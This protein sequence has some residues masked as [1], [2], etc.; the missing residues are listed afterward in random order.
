MFTGML[1]DAQP[2]PFA[3]LLVII[4]VVLVSLSLLDGDHSAAILVDQLLPEGWPI[5]E[6]VPPAEASAPWPTAKP[7]ATPALST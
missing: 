6:L 3:A 7:P 4:L 2:S 1:H 5:A